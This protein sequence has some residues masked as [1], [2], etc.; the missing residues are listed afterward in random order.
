MEL[1]AFEAYAQ[2]VLGVTGPN[3]PEPSTIVE[4]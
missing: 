4:T 2:I 3:G 1:G